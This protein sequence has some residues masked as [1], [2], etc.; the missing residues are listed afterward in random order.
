MKE[1]EKLGTN[2]AREEKQVSWFEDNMGK[3]EHP[4][5]EV[6]FQRVGFFNVTFEKSHPPGQLFDNCRLQ[7]L[8]SALTVTPFSHK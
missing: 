1:G 5:R 8:L 3:W 7:Y 4:Q 6:Y 2:E